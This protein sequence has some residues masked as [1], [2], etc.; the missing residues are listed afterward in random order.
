MPTPWNT[1]SS[2]QLR[3]QNTALKAILTL[4]VPGEA[5]LLADLCGGLLPLHT[6]RIA[7]KVTLLLS[8]L[9]FHSSLIQALPSSSS[10]NPLLVY[11]FT[12]LLLLLFVSTT[13]TVLLTGLLARGKLRAEDSPI[14]ALNG[15]QHNRGKPGPN[16]EEAPGAR[17]GSRRS[18]A[19]AAD[20]I[21]FHVYVV[22]VA[23]SQIIFIVLWIW[24]TC[25]SEPAPGAAAPHGGQHRL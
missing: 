23:C 3:L 13:E 5:L 14:P 2:F 6:E 7:Y 22:G 18:W 16:P 9:V 19:E 11:Y 21:F 15:E 4:L 17:K 12:I 25:K 1:L 10:C 24:A 8:Y 20:H